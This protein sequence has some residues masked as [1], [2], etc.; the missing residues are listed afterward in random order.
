MRIVTWNCNM[1]L[2][3]K[4]QRLLTLTPDIAVI[5]EC[6]SPRHASS[7]ET[8]GAVGSSAWTGKIETKGLGVFAF[9]DYTVRRLPDLTEPTDPQFIMPLHV[10]GPMALGLLAVWAQSETGL[11][12]Y[13]EGVHQGV[14]KHDA[15]L[16]KAD[17]VVA[18]DLNSSAAFDNQVGE[19]NH[20]TLVRELERKHALVSAYHLH[21][22][23]GHGQETMGSFFMYRKAEAPFHLDYLFVPTHWTIKSVVLGEPN[24]WLQYSDHCPLVVEVERV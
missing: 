23:E 14:H 8:H 1:A 11:R 9:G 6:A 21:R 15:F 16:R 10:E 20:S 3:R 7:R 5:P 18:G 4:W 2:H 12:G 19:V 24:E 13:V 17:C 22:G